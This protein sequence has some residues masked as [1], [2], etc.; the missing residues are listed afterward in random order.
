VCSA[1]AIALA[2]GCWLQPPHELL[3][4]LGRSYRSRSPRWNQPE[5]WALG[6]HLVR[7]TTSGADVDGHIRLTQPFR[8][9]RRVRASDVYNRTSPNLRNRSRAA[10]PL[11]TGGLSSGITISI[12]SSRMMV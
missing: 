1:T 10:V 4:P 7:E 5:L 9:H 6:K 11:M 3:P 8:E 2:Q 12:A